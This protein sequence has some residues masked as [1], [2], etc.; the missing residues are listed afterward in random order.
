MNTKVSFPIKSRNVRRY[1][2]SEYFIYSTE[3]F[4]EKFEE[5][6]VVVFFPRNRSSISSN[7]AM[8]RLLLYMYIQ[9]SNFSLRWI[10]DITPNQISN[11]LLIQI[12]G[13]GCCFFCWNLIAKCLEIT[14]HLDISIYCKR[15]KQLRILVIHLWHMT[16]M[17]GITVS[18]FRRYRL[19]T[20]K[21]TKNDK[22]L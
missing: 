14:E 15:R 20:I 9:N 22:E 4:L 11:Q 5:M 13:F 12:C 10:L 19:I 1:M 7:L 18:T 3:I 8:H 16:Y 17:L 2:D 6:C 21:K